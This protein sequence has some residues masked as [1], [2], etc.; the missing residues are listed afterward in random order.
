[1]GQLR[2][3][4]HSQMHSQ[5]RFEDSQRM[6]KAAKFLKGKDNEEELLDEVQKFLRDA[7]SNDFV[8]ALLISTRSPITRK[9]RGL[10]LERVATPRGFCWCLFV[11]PVHDMTAFVTAALSVALELAVDGRQAGEATLPQ[12]VGDALQHATDG[13]DV[14][15][16]RQG[17]Q[18]TSAALLCHLH[19]R[20]CRRCYRQ[21]PHLRQRPCALW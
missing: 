17:T 4:L 15:K 11:S 6:L 13:R 1:M 19:S 5:N 2:S 21:P 7:A 10:H 8:V 12:D 16:A 18:S 20:H 9:R 3:W 14:A